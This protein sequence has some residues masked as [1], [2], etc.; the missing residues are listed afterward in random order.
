MPNGLYPVPKFHPR[1]RHA[2]APARMRLRLWWHRT[3]LDEQLAAGAQPQPGTLLHLRAEELGSRTERDRLAR[4]LEKTVRAAYRPA[5]K[6]GTS[7]P[8]RRRVVRET[9]EDIVALVGR[10]RDTRPIDVQ[11][12]AMVEVLLT[13]PCGPLFRAGALS[14]RFSVRSARLALD[15]TDEYAVELLE[16][17]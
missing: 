16:A 3:Q 15:H 5:P 14:L 13:D 17:A 4:A 8:L 6:L 7:L 9:E 12:V 1:R 10:L 11:G 2:R